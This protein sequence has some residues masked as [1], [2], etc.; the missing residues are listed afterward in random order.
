MGNKIGF[1][2]GV[3]IFLLFAVP[4]VLEMQKTQVTL[5]AMQQLAQEVAILIEVEGGQT[6]RVNQ[7]ISEATQQ[8]EKNKMNLD[9][10]VQQLNGST[11]AEK[12]Q[13]A[14]QFEVDVHVDYQ[15]WFQEQ[16]LVVQTSGIILKR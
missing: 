12:S 8:Y 1:L 16:D 7:I 5:A 14:T 10:N 13:P 2:T 9:V 4:M 6:S 3:T 11:V 15:A